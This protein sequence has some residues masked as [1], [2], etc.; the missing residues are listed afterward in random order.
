MQYPNITQYKEAILD[1]DTFATIG[2]DIQPVKEGKDVVMASGNFACVFKMRHKGKF[3]ALKCF[4][5]DILERS[6]RQKQIV[7]YIKNNPSPYFIDY[8]YL[9]NELWIDINGGMEVPV[10]WMEWIEAPT[11]GQKIK[12]YCDTDN[13]DGLRLLTE[14]FREF[15]LWI[16]DQPFAHGDLKHDNIL[17]KDDGSLVMVD[18]D[19]M[20]IPEFQGK[21]ALELGSKCYQ[22]PQR[23]IYFFD[24]NLDDFSILIIYISL[25]AL[26]EFP[27]WYSKYNNGQNIIF[28]YGDLK[29]YEDSGLIINFIKFS[30]FKRE[31]CLL[32]E[33]LNRNFHDYFLINV[34]EVIK[35]Q[36]IED[37][38][39][40]Y[41]SCFVYKDDSAYIKIHEIFVRMDYFLI[42]EG[43]M[44]GIDIG[45]NFI[46]KRDSN[47]GVI[48]YH[49]DKIFDAIPENIKDSVVC[50]LLKNVKLSAFVTKKD[51]YGYEYCIFLE[52]E[53]DNG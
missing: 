45:D 14:K 27:E 42:Q 26:C 7:E 41:S 30:L 22:H 16:L 18:Y 51:L 21:K 15:A 29:N 5:K 40:T 49:N 46:L 9:E 52:L 4:T 24:N 10:S 20:F 25:I 50:L 8:E 44:D 11:L 47:N 6:E 13:K 17:V 32:V 48:L 43:F 35:S 1:S 33:L 31:T 34:R 2:D 28:D 53:K 39:L 36:Y 38:L 37:R 12:E 3:R 19:G 23:D